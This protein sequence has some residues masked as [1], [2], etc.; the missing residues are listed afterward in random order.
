MFQANAFL[1]AIENKTEPAC[2][3]NEAEQTLRVSLAALESV[4][5][6]AWREIRREA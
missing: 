5:D 3:L 6:G 1:D 4:D 2:N